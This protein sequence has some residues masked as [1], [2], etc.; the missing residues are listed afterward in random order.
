MR[1]EPCRNSAAYP[2]G[3]TAA[4]ESKQFFGDTVE[5]RSIVT[6]RNHDA[7]PIVQ[8]VLQRAQGVEVEVVGWLVEQ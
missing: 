1:G 4:V 8:E 7:W 3:A 5:D 2:V 6:D